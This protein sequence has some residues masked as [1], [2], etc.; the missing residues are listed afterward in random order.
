[1]SKIKIS[2]IATLL[3]GNF[4][5]GLTLDDLK[6]FDASGTVSKFASNA[7][8]NIDT[9]FGSIGCKLK[10]N[11]IKEYANQVRGGF[12]FVHNLNLDSI[13]KDVFNGKLK[14]FGNDFFECK[15][16]SGCLSDMHSAIEDGINK[17]VKLGDKA[18][19][20]SIGRIGQEWLQRNVPGYG[21]SDKDKWK[22]SQ[23]KSCK[24]EDETLQN[25][26]EDNMKNARKLN[27][28]LNANFH[29]TEIGKRQLAQ[30]SQEFQGY[31]KDSINKSE[32]MGQPNGNI[33]GFFNDLSNIYT[34]EKLA[35]LKTDLSLQITNQSGNMSENETETFEQNLTKAIDEFLAEARDKCMESLDEENPKEAELTS[36]VDKA[37]AEFKE[38][39]YDYNPSDDDDVLGLKSNGTNQGDDTGDN[40]NEDKD[41][42]ICGKVL[43]AKNK[44]RMAKQGLIQGLKM[45]ANPTQQSKYASLREIYATAMSE[46]DRAKA[47]AEYLQNFYKELLEGTKV[48]EQIALVNELGRLEIEHS[49]SS[50]KPFDAGTSSA[51][52]AM[53]VSKSKKEA[54][55]SANIIICGEKQCSDNPQ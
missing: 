31:F 4:V 54:E 9:M 20:K 47:I 34:D 39:C 5:Y 33:G 42:N 19:F 35:K 2:L 41:N 46:D 14:N 28:F 22:G 3:M 24:F 40:T 30:Y 12:N 13:I 37:Y 25:K 6:E 18:E 52:T 17:F 1:M 32:E 8:I 11:K 49:I 21:K 38:R 43:A 48:Q 36:C 53:I 29:P 44:Q 45:M 23:T 26:N 55:E 50:A 16:N 15:V 10:A 51:G 27:N 7:G